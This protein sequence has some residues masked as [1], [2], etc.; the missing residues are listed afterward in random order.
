MASW[1][2]VLSLLPLA[3]IGLIAYK[4][5]T[6]NIKRQ[7]KKARK[8]KITAGV[9]KSQG[10]SPQ[11]GKKKTTT[12]EAPAAPAATESAAES[13]NEGTDKTK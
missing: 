4:L 7:E 5:I 3:V 8:A 10:K 12:S 13:A 2:L 11:A 6:D 1:I 9:A